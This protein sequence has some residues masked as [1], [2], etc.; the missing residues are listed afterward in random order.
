MNIEFCAES[1]KNRHSSL[2]SGD[3]R[4]QRIRCDGNRHRNTRL[5]RAEV[6]RCTLEVR[7]RNNSGGLRSLRGGH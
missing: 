3:T 5:A 2:V 7:L 4:A 6:I 1:C